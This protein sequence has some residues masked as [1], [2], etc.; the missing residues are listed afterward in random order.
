MATEEQTSHNTT[1]SLYLGARIKT[2]QCLTIPNREVTKL[3]FP[4]YKSGSPTGDVTFIIRKALDSPNDT[5]L[6]SKV[7]GDASALLTK[8]TW[9]EVEFTIPVT[10]NEEVRLLVEFANGNAGNRVYYCYQLSDVKANECLTY[11]VASY[12]DNEDYDGAYIYTYGAPP[13]LA[14]RSFGYIIG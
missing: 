1:I 4:L 11:Y 7:W 9:E 2:G 13:P 12:T 3:S 10:I 6:N 5:I 8:V 14:G